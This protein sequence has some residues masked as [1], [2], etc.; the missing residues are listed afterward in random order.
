MFRMWLFTVVSLMNRSVPISLLLLP[1][2]PDV[3]LLDLR[4]PMLNG[5]GVIKELHNLDA[6]ARVIVHTTYD[7]A[8]S[9][10]FSARERFAT[11]DCLRRT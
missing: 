2:R 5:V 4:M 10:I 3:S 7:S 9:S 1:R 6:S 8:P 11:S